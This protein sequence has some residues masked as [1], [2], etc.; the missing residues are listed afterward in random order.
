MAIYKWFPVRVTGVT[1]DKSS[2]I[3]LN[4]GDTQQLTATVS[5]ANAENKSVV[6]STSDA[7]VATVDQT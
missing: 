1:L 5:P 7:T 4:A 3:M 6:W 2:L